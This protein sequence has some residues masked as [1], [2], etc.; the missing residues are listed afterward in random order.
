MNRLI[1]YIERIL[2]LLAALVA[3]SFIGVT[4]EKIQKP[5]GLRTHSLICIGA[6]FLTQLSIHA[7][8]GPNGGDPGRVAA[9]IVSGIGFLGAGTI[10]KKGF[11]VKGLTTAATLW[12]TAAVGMGFGSADYVLATALTIFVLLIVLFLKRLDFLQARSK[13][14]Q[15]I[16]EAK[17]DL[18]ILSGISEYLKEK[19]IVVHSI[20]IETDIDE[21]TVY[22]E[23]PTKQIGDIR[24]ILSEFLKLPGIRSADI[25]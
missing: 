24:A 6:A 7:F 13:E 11:S 3:G 20:E 17:N 23:F 8:S 16:I 2:Q 19:N 21:A 25:G 1:P 10:L 5:A 9:Q 18:E 14:K 22:I 12:V 15:L 4:R